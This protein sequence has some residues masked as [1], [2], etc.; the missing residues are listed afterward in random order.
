MLESNLYSA[1]IQKILENQDRHINEL[2]RNPFLRILYR[3]DKYDIQQSMSVEEHFQKNS[4]VIKKVNSS[5]IR[6]TVFNFKFILS[7]ISFR[8]KNKID[9][10]KEL[11]SSGYLAVACIVKNEARY[12]REWIDFHLVAGVDHIII[13]DNGSTDATKNIIRKYVLSGAVTYIYYPG[14]SAQYYAY[15][16]AARLSRKKFKWLALIDADEFL[17]PVELDSL[18]NVLKDYEEYPA[19]GVNWIVFGPSGHSDRPKGDVI[20]NYRSTF[21][22]YNNEMNC[23]IKSIVQPMKVKSVPSPHFCYLKNGQFA[24]DENKMEISGA[25][26]YTNVGMAFTFCNNRKVIRINHYWTKSLEDLREKCE[27]GYPDGT[28]NPK[29][30]ETLKRL[31]YPMCEDNAIL[32]YVQKR[33]RNYE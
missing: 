33:R 8:K 10:I 2:K 18:V 29:Y 7:W 30:D 32:D 19:L 15:F 25:A 6:L 13:F 14:E 3:L 1:N 28:K 26:M 23:R 16:D 27:R 31:D 21:C 12:I 5:K 11:D 22:D 20:D 24:V 17:F 9:I 4:E